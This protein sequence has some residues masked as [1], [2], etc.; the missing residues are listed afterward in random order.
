MDL[1]PFGRSFRGGSG[2]VGFDPKTHGQLLLLCPPKHDDLEAYRIHLRIHQ[3][4][5]EA[6]S[7]MDSGNA[8]LDKNQIN[9][10]CICAIHDGLALE[11]GILPLSMVVCF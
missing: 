1:S 3:K 5:W 8:E 6:R 9:C 10:E 7:L 4:K 2:D 11:D